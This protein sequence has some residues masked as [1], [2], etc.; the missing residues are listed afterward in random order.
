MQKSISEGTTCQTSAVNGFTRTQKINLN[1][2]LI[3]CSL[4]AYPTLCCVYSGWGCKTT[5]PI[6]HLVF[7]S[8]TGFWVLIAESS[9]LSPVHRPTLRRKCTANHSMSRYMLLAFWELVCDILSLIYRLTHC[10]AQILEE[11]N[12]H[13]SVITREN[14]HGYL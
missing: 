9:R 7:E 11:D 6:M 12:G 3:K 5:F 13:V 10:T 4:S 1:K 14:P 8:P 2:S